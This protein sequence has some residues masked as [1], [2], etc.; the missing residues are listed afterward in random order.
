LFGCRFP[1]ATFLDI[2]T[3]EDYER[4]E[5]VLSQIEDRE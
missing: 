2:G 4:A 5:T 3:P 1:N